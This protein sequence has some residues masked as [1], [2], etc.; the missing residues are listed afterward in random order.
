MKNWKPWHFFAAAIAVIILDQ[1]VKYMVHIN[2]Y[3]HESIPVFGNWFSIHY[4]TNEGMAWGIT[5]AGKYGKLLLTSFRI[6]VACFIPVYI[7]KLYRNGSNKVLIL[8]IAFILAGA[9]GNLVDS[10]FYGLLDERLLVHGSLFPLL[11]GKV[12]DMFYADIYNGE[13]FGIH[14][15]L[16]PVFNVADASIF[17]SVATILIFNKKFFP[18]KLEDNKEEDNKESVIQESN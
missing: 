2:L 3:E 8:C 1:V 17:C 9:V 15:N 13:L 16:W 5:I 11:H 12:I 4:E 7:L 18:E 14:L 6:I 10:I